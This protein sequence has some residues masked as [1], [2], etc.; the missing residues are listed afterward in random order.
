MV[1]K[2]NL[3]SDKKKAISFIELVRANGIPVDSAFIF[4]SRVKGKVH[5]GSDLDICLVSPIFSDRFDDRLRLMRLR[6]EIDY[7]IEPHPFHPKDFVDENPLVWEIK[8][9]GKRLV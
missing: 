9:T 5:S 2:R 4:G 1:K 7:S 3:I 8:R 6:R